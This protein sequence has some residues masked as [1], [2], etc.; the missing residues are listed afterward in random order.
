[1]HDANRKPDRTGG[2]ALLPPLLIGLLFAACGGG[3]D[4]SSGNGSGS[5]STVAA[6]GTTYP[7]LGQFIDAPV[8]GITYITPTL[9][10]MTDSNGMFSYMDGE[11]ITFKI[12]DVVLGSAPGASIITPVTLAGSGATTSSPAATNMAS[13]LQSLDQNGGSKSSITIPYAASFALRTSDPVNGTTVKALNAAGF[14]NSGV[15]SSA[16]TSLVQSVARGYNSSA[17]AISAANAQTAMENVLNSSVVTGG[18]NGIVNQPASGTFMVVTSL[19][20]Q[21]T[22]T[23][24]P[25]MAASQNAITDGWV[26]DE[27]TF[28]VPDNPVSIVLHLFGSDVGTNL[29]F[30]SL[31]SPQGTAID[32]TI[33]GGC[34]SGDAYCTLMVPYKPELPASAGTWRYALQSTTNALANFTVKLTTRYGTTPTTTTL[35]VQPY[36]SGT[37]YSADTINAALTRLVSTYAKNNVNITVNPVIQIT[38]SRYTVTNPDFTSANTSAMVS[39]GAPNVVNLFFVQDFSDGNS[40]LLGRAAGVPGSLGLASNRNGVLIGVANHVVNGTVD[41]VL[42]GDTAAHEMGH[43]LGLRHTT[44]STGKIFDPLADTPQ[45][46]VATYDANNDGSVSAEECATR[47]GHNLM[48]WVAPTTANFDKSVLTPNQQ[49][50]IRTSPLAVSK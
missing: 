31:T 38:D 28:L 45:C 43:F 10:S 37:T 14:G 32:L 27:K 15:V 26:S 39:S 3:G 48:F 19:G 16:V 29:T 40:N 20:D 50:I 46:P 11:T 47:D 13:L 8:E 6:A 33:S 25:K 9:T 30:K 49:A 12:G 36:L 17:T 34:G 24:Q 21:S 23:F 44:E 18:G 42:M 35:I 5:T 22:F 4:S 7:K 2:L 1:M 41:T